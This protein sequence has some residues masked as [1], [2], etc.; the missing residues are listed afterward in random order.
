MIVSRK[1]S[2]KILSDD[3]KILW[4]G[5]TITL[6]DSYEELEPGV[7]AI[8][9]FHN[10]R[11]RVERFTTYIPL[12]ID[13]FKVLFGLPKIGRHR[14]EYFD[15]TSYL[16]VRE[17]GFE[18]HLDD[19][20]DENDIFKTRLFRWFV[21]L[22]TL[23]YRKDMIF[24]RY[25]GI[26]EV[27]SKNDEKID[28]SRNDPSFVKDP[29]VDSVAKEMLYGYTLSAL[30]DKCNDIIRR[31]D[32]SLIWITGEIISRLSLYGFLTDDL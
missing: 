29:R 23:S 8:D 12:V 24:R 20:I 22:P 16:I 7:Y 31:I 18:G 9:R 26:T 14:L 30:R 10:E 32:P 15:D 17:I 4:D 21:G 25:F 13:E 5:S 3:Q 6:L 2:S 1:Q 11:F 28:F 19:I 27:I